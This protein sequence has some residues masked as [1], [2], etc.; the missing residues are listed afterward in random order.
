M[1]LLKF[2]RVAPIAALLMSVA[3]PFAASAAT[4]GG[5]LCA[6]ASADPAAFIAHPEFAARLVAMSD[7]CPEL[8]FALTN[9]TGSIPEIDAPSKDATAK[10]AA[11]AP[12]YSDVLGRLASATKTLNG[13][14]K[15][16]AV[17]QAALER[18]IRRAKKIGLTDDDLQLVVVIRADDNMDS[19]RR[20]LPDWQGP[21]TPLNLVTVS[22][23]WPARLARFADELAN[24][25]DHGTSRL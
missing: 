4:S 19:L 23:L 8:A 6:S 22:R 20:V 5:A 13:A 15:D 12:D 1:S 25:L 10:A 21:D 24:G 11:V 14:T 2:R 18:T 17:A 7:A 9:S 16:V 3:I